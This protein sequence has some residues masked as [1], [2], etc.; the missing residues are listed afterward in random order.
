M[1]DF[2]ETSPLEDVLAKITDDQKKSFDSVL[3]Y[4]RPEH[5]LD[6]TVKDFTGH[7]GGAEDLTMELYSKVKRFAQK[8]NLVGN[9]DYDSMASVLELFVLSA[10][11]KMPSEDAKFQAKIFQAR[12]GAGEF[13]SADKKVQALASYAKKHL[14]LDQKQVV[15]GFLGAMKT[16]DPSSFY[17]GLRQ[18]SDALAQGM[19][20]T[21][22]QQKYEKAIL[23]NEFAFNA[24]TI[25]R[26]REDYGLQ[27]RRPLEAMESGS[28]L[29]DLRRLWGSKKDDDPGFAPYTPPA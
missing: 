19:V 27:P 22:T 16:G 14:G 12:V 1:G 20:S 5:Q 17:T 23:G 3:D 15:S 9:T 29:A 24:Y 7:A 28:G 10:L 21:I 11:L 2:M 6:L 4:L 8:S 26:M 18:L 13:G 25:Q